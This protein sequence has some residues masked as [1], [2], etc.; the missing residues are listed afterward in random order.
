MIAQSVQTLQS[1]YKAADGTYTAIFSEEVV[2]DKFFTTWV[3]TGNLT[4]A[5]TIAKSKT[6]RN[7]IEAKKTWV[8]TIEAILEENEAR[9][10]KELL[11]E[12]GFQYQ[13]SD[14]SPL[15]NWAT[16]ALNLVGGC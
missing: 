16:W 9:E 4:P 3:G 10:Y 14:L 11:D 1:I 12:K 5:G 2:E 15:G 7:V 6:L 13:L 8:E